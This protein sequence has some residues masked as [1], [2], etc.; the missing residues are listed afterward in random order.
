MSLKFALPFLLLACSGETGPVSLP[1]S[2][3]PYVPDGSTGVVASGGGAGMPEISNTTVGQAGAVSLP[4]EDGV[5]GAGGQAGAGGLAG[6]SGGGG[7]PSAGGTGGSPA[8]GGGSAGSAGSGGQPLFVVDAGTDAA[9]VVSTDAGTSLP[10]C[11]GLN[12]PCCQDGAQWT[13]DGGDGT[14]CSA[15][16]YCVVQ[17]CAIIGGECCEGAT[18][19]GEFVCKEAVCAHNPYCGREGQ[20]ACFG[21]DILNR[22]EPGLYLGVEGTCTSEPCGEIGQ[23]CCPGELIVNNVILVTGACNGTYYTA[24]CEWPSRRCGSSVP[25]PG[26]VCHPQLTN[27]GGDSVCT[28]QACAQTEGCLMGEPR[29][30]VLP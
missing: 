22:C 2:A 9:P 11:G 24:I 5:A 23:L 28:G 16:H 7:V 1:D 26:N 14:I 25:A 18:C 4:P 12:E 29:R 30:C 13:C 15:D 10:S 21:P 3:P 6:A 8:G 19:H 17:T 27:C 20:P